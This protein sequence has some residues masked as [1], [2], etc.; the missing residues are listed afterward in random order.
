MKLPSPIYDI[1]KKYFAHHGCWHLLRSRSYTQRQRD[2]C[3]PAGMMLPNPLRYMGEKGSGE[4]FLRF[5]RLML[6]N[7]KWIIMSA[8]PPK[9]EYKPWNDLPVWLASILDA[10]DPNY[11]SNLGRRINYL[12]MSGSLD[13][14][15][16][17]I[18]G[19]EGDDTFPHIHYL[20]HDVVAD[21]ECQHFGP[22]PLCDM[23]DMTVACYNEHF[24]GF[25]GWI[26]DFYAQWQVQH[27]EYA[28]QGP[29]EPH[30]HKMCPRCMNMDSPVSLYHRWT[31]YLRFR[32]VVRS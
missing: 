24:W 31:E 27:G 23:A 25:H 32:S 5:H 13:D 20:V 1:T 29:L 30:D 9:Y 10:M 4:D 21:Y 7:F 14:L 22:Q 16:Q 8:L 3:F 18:E 15:G 11:R 26:D 12:V 17:F 6:R 2:E 28:E 19:E